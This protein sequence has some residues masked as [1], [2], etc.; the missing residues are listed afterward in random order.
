MEVFLIIIF[1]LIFGS[2]I[3]MASYRLAIEDNNIIDLIIRRSFCP[4]CN[5]I[6]KAKNLFPI[7]SWIFQSGKC[8]YCNSKIPFRYVLIEI[9]TAILFVITFLALDQ[10]ISYHLLII[11]L[12][13][14]TL[15]IMSVVDLEHYF[16]PN[17]TQIILLIL[18]ISYHIFISKDLDF[19][20]HLLSAFLYALFIYSIFY[21][22]LIIRGK[23]VIGSDDLKFFP[24]AGIFLGMDNFVYF[25]A[26]LGIS[27]IIYGMVWVSLT[28]DRCFPFAPALSFAL[29]MNLWSF[30]DFSYI[31][32]LLELIILKY[33]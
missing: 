12:T 16:I 24:I 22:F 15:M 33:I 13:I 27:G 18:A 19:K 9:F 30:T 20:N 7:L 8:S 28:K 25:I 6:L 11:L 10:K 31:S 21:I 1:G 14:V 5:H 32:D 4:K 29:M 26:F 2:F 23:Y 17:I 3:S